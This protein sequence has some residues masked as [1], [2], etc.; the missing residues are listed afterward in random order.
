M[1]RYQ[2]DIICDVPCP[3]F[4]SGFEIKMQHLMTST[5]PGI[6]CDLTG[7]SCFFL[8]HVLSWKFFKRSLNIELFRAKYV[9]LG[10]SILEPP[11]KKK[12]IHIVGIDSN[13]DSF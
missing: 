7:L 13:F 2:S 4:L 8:T 6:S 3:S 10:V 12:K 1:K 5:L 9:K 11:K